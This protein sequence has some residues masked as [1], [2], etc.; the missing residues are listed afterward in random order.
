MKQRIAV[1]TLLSYF[2][3]GCEQLKQPILPLSAA[4]AHYG[5]GVSASGVFALPPGLV[6]PVVR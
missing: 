2:L 5:T 1:V 6:L 3:V 4:G